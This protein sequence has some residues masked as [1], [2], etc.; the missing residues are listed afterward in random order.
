MVMCALDH[1]GARSPQVLSGLPNRRGCYKAQPRTSISNRRPIGDK[2]LVHRSILEFCQAPLKAGVRLGDFIEHDKQT[3]DLIVP[4]A[5]I[6]T[7]QLFPLDVVV[8][9]HRQEG[10]E[11]HAEQ[12]HE[13]SESGN[14][15]PRDVGGGVGH[16]HWRGCHT[17]DATISA[18]GRTWHDG[19]P[20]VRHACRLRG[21]RY[22]SWPVPSVARPNATAMRHRG[23]ASVAVRGPRGGSHPL[24]LDTRVALASSHRRSR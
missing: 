19:Y 18:E 16:G 5:S 8:G 7:L 6:L 17:A 10:R 21:S 24:I 15:P 1:V 22:R 23:E 14:P 12:R 2:S 4:L 9:P 3:E 20:G 11:K 13:T